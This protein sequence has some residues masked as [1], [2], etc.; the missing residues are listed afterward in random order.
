LIL[1]GVFRHL[2]STSRESG[3]TEYFAGEIRDSYPG[4]IRFFGEEMSKSA[5][6]RIAMV[7]QNPEDQLFM[8]AL[9]D[10]VTLPL[11]NRGLQISEAQRMALD[12]LDKLGLRDLAGRPA[13]KLSIGE[14]K[15]ASIAAALITSP[16]QR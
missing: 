6:A 13:T 9:L 5:L 16:L 12:N 15:R 1:T 2:V 14:R 8:P 3:L 10:G 11:V 7:F 4:S